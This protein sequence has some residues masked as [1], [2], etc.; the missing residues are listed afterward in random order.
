MVEEELLYERRAGMLHAI[1]MCQEEDGYRPS[2]RD[3]S[4]MQ[5]NC[6]LYVI[7][8]MIHK[9]KKKTCL[10]VYNGEMLLGT[11]LIFVQLLS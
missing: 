10:S 1:T 6:S 9:R 2:Y 4:N 8:Y 3:T 11:E 5:Q 7:H